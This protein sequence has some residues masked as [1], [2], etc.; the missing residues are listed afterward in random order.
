MKAKL[1]TI[2]LAAW[3]AG[4]AALGASAGTAAAAA[5]S[6]V[7]VGVTE[8]IAS[9]NPYAD[10]VSLAYGIWCQVYGC[11]GI[12]DFD[13]GDYVGMLAERWENDKADPN[14]WTF[15]LRHGVKR[16]H[17]GKEFSAADVVHSFERVNYRSAEPAEAEYDPGQGDGRARR[18]HGEGRHQGPDRVA[19][20]ISVRPVHHHR[21]RTFT[22]NTAR[23]TP[24]ANIP[25]AGGHTSSRSW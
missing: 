12:F 17:D 19:A 2:L 23:A 4:A 3:I 11:L 9:Y 8:T 1:G 7:A 5:K 10:S 13:K 20:R 24:T 14:V 21:R 15:H 6:Q 25:G 16:Q 18:L 22:T